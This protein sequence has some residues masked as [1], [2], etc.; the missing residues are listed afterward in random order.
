MNH[1]TFFHVS[2][3]PAAAHEFLISEFGEDGLPNNT[4]YGDGSAIE[5]E[6][7]DELRAA[8][9][10]ETVMFPWQQSDVLVVDNMLA[11]HARQPFTGPR[12]VVVGMSEPVSWDHVQLKVSD[13]F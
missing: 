9:R 3:L 7:L 8:Y 13:L 2:T 10:E 4:Y 11:A 6:V 1:A 5:P 12:K